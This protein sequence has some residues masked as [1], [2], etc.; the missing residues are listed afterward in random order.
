MKES[1]IERARPTVFFFI[2]I[3]FWKAKQKRKHRSD[4]NRDEITLRHSR[5]IAQTVSLKSVPRPTSAPERPPLIRNS[6]LQRFFFS[7]FFSNVHILLSSEGRT[8]A[9]WRKDMDADSI[10]ITSGGGGGGQKKRNSACVRAKGLGRRGARYTS[11]H[12]RD[13]TGCARTRGIMH[14]HHVRGGFLSCTLLAHT[15]TALC[16][17]RCCCYCW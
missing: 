1:S 13:G 17:Y 6:L 9:L 16:C 8:T 7:F 5:H 12:T 2:F 15:H 3:L 14:S 11:P 10:W 4:V